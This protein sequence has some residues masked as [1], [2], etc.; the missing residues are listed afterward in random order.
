MGHQKAYIVHL[1][2]PFLYCPCV[3]QACV[4]E[5]IA[6]SKKAERGHAARGKR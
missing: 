6:K 2:M 5:R 3:G 4:S 1:G